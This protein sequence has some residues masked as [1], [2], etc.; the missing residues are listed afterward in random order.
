M[1]TFLQTDHI[2]VLLQINVANLSAYCVRACKIKHFS[3]REFSGIF[4][5]AGGY[6]TLESDVSRDQTVTSQRGMIHG[7]STCYR[8]LAEIRF[9]YT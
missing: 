3:E 1:Y 9:N 8:L 7:D 4:S 2:I 6:Y 5:L